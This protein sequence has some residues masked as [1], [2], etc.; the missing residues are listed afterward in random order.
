MKQKH[1]NFGLRTKKNS[2]QTIS[3]FTHTHT[4]TKI[5]WSRNKRKKDDHHQGENI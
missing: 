3:N 4:H 5:E 2:R 1:T